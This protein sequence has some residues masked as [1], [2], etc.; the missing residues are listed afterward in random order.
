MACNECNDKVDVIIQSSDGL[1]HGA[2]S[3]NLELY[4]GAFP[5]T[6]FASPADCEVNILELT[7]TS[8][9]VVLM[10]KYVHN[11]QQPNSEEIKF[12]VMVDLAEAVEE[13][14]IYSA[15]EVCRLHMKNAA[16]LHPMDVLAWA[17]RHGYMEI[18]DLAAPGTLGLT[19]ESVWRSLGPAPMASWIF[20][21]EPY[22]QAIREASQ[23]PELPNHRVNNRDVP[24]DWNSRYQK[25]TLEILSELMKDPQRIHTVNT[26]GREKIPPPGC[27]ICTGQSV[28][29]MIDWLNSLANKA[30]TIP[31]F[32]IVHR[33]GPA[34]TQPTP[35]Q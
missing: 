2:H 18:A 13:Y 24:C 21:R 30:R 1:L 23:R 11:R 28:S 8:E 19:L 34:R 14:Q 6:S 10:L 5:S 3:R 9:V 4:S 17:A 12:E 32:S 26:W 31:A 25:P 22:M 35:T 15:M 29:P 20:Y 16:V 33:G 27:D 7:E